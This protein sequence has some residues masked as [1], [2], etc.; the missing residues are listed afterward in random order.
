MVFGERIKYDTEA[1]RPRAADVE[2][3]T[4]EGRRTDAAEQSV[5]APRTVPAPV[6]PRQADGGEV[7]QERIEV[8]DP[9]ITNRG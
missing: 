4:E 9:A 3:R 2:V 7:R 1:V 5:E 6:I 8:D